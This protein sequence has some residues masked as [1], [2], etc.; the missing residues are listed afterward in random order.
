MLPFPILLLAQ[1]VPRFAKAAKGGHNRIFAPILVTL[2]GL[3]T[4][5]E[6]AAVLERDLSPGLPQAAVLGVA[7]LLFA[8]GGRI[9][10]AATAG[11]LRVKGRHLKDRVQRPL[12][13][14]GLAALACAALALLLGR[15]GLAGAS[16]TLAALATLMR[17]ARWRGHELRERADIWALHLGYAWLGVGL[18]LA[19]LESWAL[20]PFASGVHAIMVG[21]L[22][23]LA[24]TM[25]ARTTRQRARRQQMFDWA[26]TLAILAISAAAALRV[27]ASFLASETLLLG[28]GLAWS[29][30]HLLLLV[31][32]LGR[33]DVRSGRAVRS[34]P[35]TD[36]DR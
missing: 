35:A 12:E 16:L 30:A 2:V 4:L 29:A 1:T 22:G 28:A 13:W 7:L 33:R 3:V 5:V 32:F 18:L 25:M 11:A 26:E 14:A 27:T 10:P 20:A 15:D 9:I 6:A 36:R 8:M 17:L 34:E 24:A 31:W 19:G 23:T 21:G